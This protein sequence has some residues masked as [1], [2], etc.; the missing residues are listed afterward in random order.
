MNTLIE[1][2]FLLPQDGVKDAWVLDN[3][4]GPLVHFVVEGELSLDDKE[5]IMFSLLDEKFFVPKQAGLPLAMPDDANQY[6]DR[7]WAAMA[8]N[9]FI[10]TTAEPTVR[11]AIPEL[12]KNIQMWHTT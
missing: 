10:P 7:V 1:Y 8:W 6:P 4:L 3:N 12:V 2:R 9:G 11:F 5:T